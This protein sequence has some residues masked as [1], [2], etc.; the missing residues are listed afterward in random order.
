MKRNY[1]SIDIVAFVSVLFAAIFF[2]FLAHEVF[3]LLTIHEVSSLTIRFGAAPIPVSVC[4]L[5]SN[6]KA[7]EEIAYFI[8][9]LV[10]IAWIAFNSRVYAKPAAQK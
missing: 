1:D 8:Q 2:G 5:Q 4:C 9:F 6:E 10:T 7:M 3:H